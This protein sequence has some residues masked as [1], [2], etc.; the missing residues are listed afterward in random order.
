MICPGMGVMRTVANTG[1]A[2]LVGAALLL[3]AGLPAKP[4]SAD[5]G[6]RCLTIEDTDSRVEC[7]EGGAGQRGNAARSSG[8]AGRG[9]NAD[10]QAAECRARFTEL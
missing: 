9:A 6:A 3:A 8:R 2:A 5:N 1:R 4:Q 10:L 7:L